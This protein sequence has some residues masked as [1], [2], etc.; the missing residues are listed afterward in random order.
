[1]SLLCYL[2]LNNLTKYAESYCIHVS[3]VNYMP[4]WFCVKSEIIEICNT[5][6]KPVLPKRKKYLFIYLVSSS[7]D[8]QFQSYA[9]SYSKDHDQ[10]SVEFQFLEKKVHCW[11][12][13]SLSLLT[14]KFIGNS[15]KK[16]IVL[17]FIG[18]AELNVP[19][20]TIIHLNF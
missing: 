20:F 12:L 15:E 16:L 11:V 14:T 3:R 2:N 6:Q 5:K 8:L 4:I 17:S 19:Q 13:D 18:I 9:D 7:S 1:M 10:K